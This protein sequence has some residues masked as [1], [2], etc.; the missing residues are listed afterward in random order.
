MTVLFLCAAFLLLYAFFGYPLVI[1]S[2]AAARGRRKKACTYKELPSVM[3]V[4]A[5]C[6]EGKRLEEKIK[7]CL[8]LDY[9]RGKLDIVAVSDASTLETLEVLK[10][11]ERE[12][13]LR[14]LYNPRRSGKSAA[15]ARALEQC[16]ADVFVV[17]DAD[18]LLEPG[19][20]RELVMPFSDS[21]VGAATAVVHYSNVEESGISWSEGLYWRYEFFTRKVESRLGRL[22][23]LSGAFYA[24][25]PELFKIKDPR[26]DADFLAPLQVLE[27]G[28]KVLLL[29]WISAKDYTPSTTRALFLRRV[30]T[31]T[32]ALWSL[33]RNA[34]Y[35]NPFRFLILSWQ[36]WSHKI[37]RWLLPVF[38]ILIF[39]S[40]AFLLTTSLFWQIL[41]GCQVLFYLAGIL[42]AVLS[43]LKVNVPFVTSIWYFMLSAWASIVAFFNL[44][45]GRDYSVWTETARR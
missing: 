14:V 37:L 44:L 19:H 29:D 38:M 42:G 16:D 40:N 17:T 21:S 12:G 36:I 8:A 3:F 18:T 28:R 9:P 1:L 35:L 13:I 23:G 22:T 45:R 2:M 24:V 30:R 31:M 5:C 32:L 33:V 41:F 26:C 20:L 6:W 7:N 15:L 10:R 11:A 34:R 39:I 25:R 27:R 43:K 4:F